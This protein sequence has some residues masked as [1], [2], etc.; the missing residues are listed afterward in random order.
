MKSP[1][2]VLMQNIDCDRIAFVSGCIKHK[3][4]EMSCQKYPSSEYLQVF[5]NLDF[6]NLYYLQVDLHLK[7]GGPEITSFRTPEVIFD[8]QCWWITKL[9]KNYYHLFT[10]V[11]NLGLTGVVT[12]GVL[13]IRIVYLM[14][15]NNKNRNMVESKMSKAGKETREKLNIKDSLV[16]KETEIIRSNMMMKREVLA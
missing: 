14:Q 4:K 1:V 3:G 11:F 9:V 12:F 2:N 6:Y 15:E 8:E 16:N 5:R 7:K 13:M 10:L